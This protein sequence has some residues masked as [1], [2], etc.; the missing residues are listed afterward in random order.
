MRFFVFTDYSP[1]RDYNG[2]AYERRN[3]TLEGL[4]SPISS[5]EFEDGTT[6]TFNGEQANL[7]Y[8]QTDNVS[9]SMNYVYD[10]QVTYVR[11]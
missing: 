6:I 5:Y 8:H 3:F 1:I 10:S 4:N 7:H 9:V 11:E 2:F